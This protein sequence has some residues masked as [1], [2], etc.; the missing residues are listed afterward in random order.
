ML[1]LAV[2]GSC[3]HHESVDADTMPASEF[4]PVDV[5]E[6]EGVIIPAGRVKDTFFA[7]RFTEVWT[8]TLEDIIR[9]EAGLRQ[10]LVDA[11]ARPVIYEHLANYRRQYLGCVVDGRRRVFVNAFI[12]AGSDGIDWHPSWARH[13]VFVLDGGHSYWRI[14]YDLDSGQYVDFEQN[15]CA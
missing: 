4:A 12:D 8:P 1:F 3:A 14:Q 2:L 10:G 9:L 5:V 7:P 13:A 15:G 11:N 6:A